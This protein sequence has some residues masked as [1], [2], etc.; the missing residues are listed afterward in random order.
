MDMVTLIRK[1]I[2]ADR[3][4]NWNLHLEA[5]T[6]MLPFFA[7][8]GH[9]NYNKSCRLYLQDMLELKN[10]DPVT[11]R[12]F[13]EGLSVI[14]RSDRF[15]AGE[16][17]DLVIEQVLMRSMKSTGAFIKSMFC[18]ALTKIFVTYRWIYSPQWN[19]RSATTEMGNVPPYM[20]IC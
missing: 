1:Y 4:G 19:Y 11:E 2:R 14:R 8:A 17:T 16:S 15:W 12:S 10:V 18:L 7:A 5:T 9:N 13:Q 6:E 3:T 20:L